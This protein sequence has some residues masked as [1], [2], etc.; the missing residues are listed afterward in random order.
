MCESAR[1]ER[2]LRLKADAFGFD[3]C[4]GKLI[5]VVEAEDTTRLQGFKR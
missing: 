2:S 1:G 3:I 5:S 4:W